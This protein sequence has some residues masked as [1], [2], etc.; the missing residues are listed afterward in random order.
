MTVAPVI[1]L[2][3]AGI[4]HTQH[5]CLGIGSHHLNLRK[6]AP[7]VTRKFTQHRMCFSEC[8]HIFAEFEVRSVFLQIFPVQPRNLIVLTVGIVIAE[9]GIQKLIAGKE[10][11]RS[12][13]AHQHGKGIHCQP[14]AQRENP[15]ICRIPFR[16]AVPAAIIVTSIRIA[17]AVGLIMLFVVG[18]QIPKSKAVMTGQEIHGR[19]VPSPF[20]IIDI[21]GTGN[22]ARSNLPHAKIPFQEIAHIIPISAIPFRP[23]A[24]GGETAHLIEAARIPRLGDQL[25][26]P[27]DRIESQTLQKRRLTHR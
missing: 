21:L 10:H 23:A 14:P 1:H 2:Y 5:L 16:T 18:I 7:A 26:I 15:F 3:P 25:H 4:D 27:Q 20:R 24:P 22:S 6:T 12:A 17:P 13:A 9:L 11:R 8:R 19:I